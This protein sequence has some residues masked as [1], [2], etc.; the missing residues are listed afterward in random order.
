MRNERGQSLAMLAV[1]LP[2]ILIIVGV[3][4]RSGQTAF[5]HYRVQKV[6]DRRALDFLEIEAQ[7]LAQLG[8]I[9]PYAK[10]II[11]TRRTLEKALRKCHVFCWQL[12]A[13]IAQLRMVQ[14]GIAAAQAGIKAETYLRAKAKMYAPLPEDIRTKVSLTYNRDPLLYV[15]DQSNYRGETGAPQTVE[16]NFSDKQKIKISADTET[17]RLLDPKNQD[18]LTWMK[19]KDDFKN[20]K[21]RAQDPMNIRT[22]ARVEMDDLEEKWQVKL[23]NQDRL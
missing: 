15:R 8:S 5:Y 11:D 18:R 9:N 1:I 3:L 23:K 16:Q 14:A 6:I 12:A 4:L 19:K 21:M 7:G 13:A 20:E 2:L 17:E 22:L 10:S